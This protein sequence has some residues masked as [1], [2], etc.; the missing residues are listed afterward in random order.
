MALQLDE[1]QKLLIHGMKLACTKDGL[2]LA[3]EYSTAAYLRDSRLLA[4]L[5]A[6][7]PGDAD[8]RMF[9]LMLHDMMMKTLQEFF[10]GNILITLGILCLANVIAEWPDQTGVYGALE[11]LNCLLDIPEDELATS[12]LRQLGGLSHA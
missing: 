10:K 12:R 2:L 11:S 7:H 5:N 1:A 9:R 8:H 3:S 4:F 6:H